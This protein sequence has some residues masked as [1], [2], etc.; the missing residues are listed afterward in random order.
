MEGARRLASVPV[1]PLAF[2][3]ID[4]A[5]RQWDEHGWEDASLGMAVVTSVMRAHQIY[6]AR[7]DEVLRPFGLTFARF[8]LLALVSFSRS[9]SLPMSKAGARLQVHPTTITNSV[10]RLEAQRMVRRRP[11]DTDRRMTLV[12]ILPAGR[13]LLAEATAALNELVFSDLGIDDGD[14]DAVVTL[15]RKVRVVAGDFEA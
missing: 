1:Q 6:L 7:V 3:P 5:R 8:E 4:A 2:D 12:E 11:H 15:L 14:M 13:A 10:D 9:G